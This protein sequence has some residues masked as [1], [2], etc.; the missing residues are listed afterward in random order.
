MSNSIEAEDKSERSRREKTTFHV[1]SSGDDGDDEEERRR[2]R[3]GRKS[4]ASSVTDA[5]RIADDAWEEEDGER[6]SSSSS[7]SSGVSDGLSDFVGGVEEKEG[8]EMV[9]FPTEWAYRLAVTKLTA[10]LKASKER[11]HGEEKAARS[12]GERADQV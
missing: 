9:R 5:V 1:R 8:R 4:T 3:R 10:K 12:A 6:S 7:S 11:L 2:A